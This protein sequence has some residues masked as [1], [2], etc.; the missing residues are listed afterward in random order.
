MAHTTKAET[1]RGLVARL[2]NAESNLVDVKRSTSTGSAEAARLKGK[3]EG[4]RL[5][6][7]YAE[8]ALR[9]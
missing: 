2:E 6:R 9:G 1:L 7:S 5:A 8:E 4:V 3:I